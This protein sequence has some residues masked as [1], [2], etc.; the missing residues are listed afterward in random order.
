MEEN[1]GVSVN[2]CLEKPTNGAFIDHVLKLQLVEAAKVQSSAP[3]P[4]PRIM[5]ERT[6]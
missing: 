4:V 2:T 1:G 6:R 3:V 5:F